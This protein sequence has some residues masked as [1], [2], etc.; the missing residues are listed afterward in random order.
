M[1]P[2]ELGLRRAFL[3]LV[4]ASALGACSELALIGHTES[5]V[6]LLPFGLAAL[7]TLAAVGVWVSPS[8]N[9]LRGLQ[10]AMTVVALGGLFGIWEHLEHN[11]S[12]EA[13]IRPAASTIELVTQAIFGA[14]PA[15]APG[16]FLV[17]AAMGFAAAWRH[18]AGIEEAAP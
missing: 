12:F 1:S 13:E 3:A 14:S 5:R 18:P 16:M 17:M 10:G 11:Y 7:G 4:V 15:L 2:V 8:K 9:M 6:Q